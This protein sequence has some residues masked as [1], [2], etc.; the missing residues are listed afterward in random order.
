MSHMS[1]FQAP[2][3]LGQPLGMLYLLSGPVEGF[4][5][6][7]LPQESELLFSILSTKL[8]VDTTLRHFFRFKLIYQ[9]AKNLFQNCLNDQVWYFHSS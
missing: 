3:P 5:P 7:E 8:S 9:L 2:H 6:S 1:Q 4:V